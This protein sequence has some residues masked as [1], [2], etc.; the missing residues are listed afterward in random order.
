MEIQELYI[1]KVGSGIEQ[2]INVNSYGN[3]RNTSKFDGNEEVYI[4][5][6]IKKVSDD[7]ENL[8]L[9]SPNQFSYE[10]ID[11]KR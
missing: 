1:A 7:R 5:A 10:Q 8:I 4:I 2:W 9:N 11:W 3:G 6:I